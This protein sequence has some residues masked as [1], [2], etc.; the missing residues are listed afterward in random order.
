MSRNHLRLLNYDF[1]TEKF[2]IDFTID[3]LK[4]IKNKIY[5]FTFSEETIY[6]SCGMPTRFKIVIASN[7]SVDSV[8]HFVRQAE[9]LHNAQVKKNLNICERKSDVLSGNVIVEFIRHGN[10][11]SQDMARE[12]ILLLTSYKLPFFVYK[13]KKTEGIDLRLDEFL[14]DKN[15]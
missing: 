1:L 15:D 8:V 4:R 13:F 14:G 3:L 9:D 10:M 2:G 11:N 12:W 6:K 7:N 5:D